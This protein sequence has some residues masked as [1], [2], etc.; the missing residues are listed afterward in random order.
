MNPALSRHLQALGLERSPFPPTPDAASY[1]STPRLES[2]LIEAAQALRMRA[3][4][5]LLSGEVGTGKSTFLRRLLAVLESEGMAVS[6]VFNTFLQGDDLLAA[7][8]RDFGLTPQGNP[9]ADIEALNRF[10]V[11]RWQKGTACVLIIDD[12][13]NLSTASLELVRLLTNLETDQEKLLQIVLSGQPELRENL[14]LPQMRQ[15]TSRICKHVQLAPLTLLDTAHYV[16]FR[17]AYAGAGDSITIAADAIKHLFRASQGN[18]RRIH[19]IMDRALYGLYGQAGQQRQL[20]AAVIA[21]AANEAGA[22]SSTRSRMPLA[23]ALALAA[24]TVLAIGVAMG[25]GLYWGSPTQSNAASIPQRHSPTTADTSPASVVAIRCSAG[26]LD[27]TS[28]IPAGTAQLLRHSP[29]LCID[30]ID[31]LWSMHW[32]SDT[33]I[34]TGDDRPDAV[35]HEL[36]QYLHDLGQYDGPVDGRYGRLTK[37]ALARLQHLYGL[38][39]TGTADL[40]TTHLLKVLHGAS[41]TTSPTSDPT[42]HGNG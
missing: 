12:A 33:P 17:L 41:I 4:F 2:E 27:Q 10:L 30:Q 11:K 16:Q 40:P 3:G 19:L 1:Y 5:V 22:L 18:P 34:S 36:Q 13:Q 7:V 25:V 29:P 9:A 14:A 24:S 28:V 32:K 8:L 23:L 31:G 42:Q 20:S 35:L 37:R 26:D 21:Q 39:A 15:L 38:P 6:L